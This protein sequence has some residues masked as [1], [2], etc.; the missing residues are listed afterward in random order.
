MTAAHVVHRQSARLTPQSDKA[1]AQAKIDDAKRLREIRALVRENNRS[2]IEED[3]IICQIYMESR[4]DARIQSDSSTAR[5]LM[6]L[7]RGTVR[8]L[9]RLQN[10]KLP[11]AE[12]RSD[13]E[14]FGAADRYH[15]SSEFL[16]EAKNIEAGTSYLQILI[17]RQ[18]SKGAADPISEAYKDYRG[19]RNG[20]YFTKI[21]AAA[22][23]LANAPED[24]EILREMVR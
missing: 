6:Q 8:E 15:D 23:K 13:A 20:I 24:M 3:V 2:Q 5:G 1:P 11:R 4:F 7:L 16:D 19:V 21:K 18:R 12:R 10:L 9:Y 22:E 14:V 17:D